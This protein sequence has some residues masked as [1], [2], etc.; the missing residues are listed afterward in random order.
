MVLKLYG[1]G[2]S[3]VRNVCQG[4]VS[5]VYKSTTLSL[6]T[7]ITNYWKQASGILSGGR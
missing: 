2:S 4:N 6:S 1:N 7:A 3:E 5:A